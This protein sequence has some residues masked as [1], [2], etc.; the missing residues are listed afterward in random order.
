MRKATVPLIL[1]AIAVSAAPSPAQTRTSRA[2]D[3][4]IVTG[5]ASRLLRQTRKMISRSLSRRLDRL[6]TS[7]LPTSTI[8]DPVVIELQFVSPEKVGPV[9]RAI[10]QSLVRYNGL[11]A[12]RSLHDSD[13]FVEP[14]ESS[15]T[16]AH[17][18]DDPLV[19]RNRCRLRS[20]SPPRQIPL[21]RVTPPCTYP[22][23]TCHP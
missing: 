17:Q 19:H 11:R 10:R 12:S 15:R 5:P 20:V 4:Y 21:E 14:A 2:L 23:G 8:S 9:E 13:R 16:A 6:E 22:P 1:L 7:I 18:S 3:I